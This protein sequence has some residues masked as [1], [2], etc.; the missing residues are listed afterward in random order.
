MK[1]YPIR[2]ELLNRFRTAKQQK[3]TI[4]KLKYGNADIVIGTHPHVIE[5][6][7]WIDDTIVFYSLGNFLSSQYQDDNYNKVVGLMSSLKITKTTKG[8]ESSIKIDD[9]ENELIF[10]YYYSEANRSNLK[11]VPFSNSD[12]AKYLPDYKN[13]YERYK[14]VVQAYDEN[15][16]VVPAHQ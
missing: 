9:V 10:T 1:E 2:I 13:V 6:V 16:Y 15:M 12:I 3:E 4:H 11:V 7:T 5:P 14:K 8:E